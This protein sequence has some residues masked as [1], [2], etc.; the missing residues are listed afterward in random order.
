MFRNI[1]LKALTSRQNNKLV[2]C[3]P[4]ISISVDKQLH[5]GQC[6]RRPRG[7]TKATN[8]TT[9]AITT[10]YQVITETNASVIEHTADEIYVNEKYPI[11]S[12]E[13]DGINLERKA[14]YL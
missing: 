2:K 7:P 11:L 8:Q 13:F 6:L 9:P 14:T 10:K 4:K 12:D 1:L 3:F 5:C